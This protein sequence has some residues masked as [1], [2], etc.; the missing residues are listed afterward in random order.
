MASQYDS[1]KTPKEL[2]TQVAMHGFSTQIDDRLRA[3]DIF[4][5]API[6]DLVELANTTGKTSENFYMVLFSIWHWTDATRF[7][8]KYSN[9]EF[10][11]MKD[12]EL[13]ILGLENKV[14]TVQKKAAEHQE[15]CQ[16]WMRRCKEEQAAHAD[17]RNEAECY[18]TL[19]EAAK[20]EIIQLKAKLYDLMVEKEEK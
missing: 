16:E 6:E 14:A 2:L 20:Q 12:K 15:D 8:N 7:Y 9:P 18:M 3:Q 13:K 1:I 5:R 19:Y 10:K 11:G 17:T 4:G